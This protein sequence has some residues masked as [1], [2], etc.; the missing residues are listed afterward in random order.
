MASES[1]P[2]A[3]PSAP[4]QSPG[5]APARYWLGRSDDVE[6]TPP[7][8]RAWLGQ[9]DPAPRTQRVHSERREIF[10]AVRECN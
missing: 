6:A 3:P 8:K 7:I 5:P 9:E 2:L 10:C 1:Q 4:P